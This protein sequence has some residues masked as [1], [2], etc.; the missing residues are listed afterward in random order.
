MYDKVFLNEYGFYELKKKPSLSS[1][2][3]DFE[4]T[5]YQESK[6]NYE[7][8]YS[9]EEKRFFESKYRQKKRIIE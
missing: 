3:K 1:M 2:K 6:G 4:D 7:Q 8:Q 5:Y 9:E